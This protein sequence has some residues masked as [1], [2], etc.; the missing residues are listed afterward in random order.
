MQSLILSQIPICLPLLLTRLKHEK[1]KKW[2]GANLDPFWSS[3]FSHNSA[4]M[5][6]QKILHKPKKEI[7]SKRVE[8]KS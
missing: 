1:W 7:I 4:A 5:H 8:S 6:E 2:V 3:N